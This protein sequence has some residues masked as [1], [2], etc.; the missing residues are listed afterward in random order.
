MKFCIFDVITDNSSLGI[1]RFN[2]LWIDEILYI[3]CDYR[4]LVVN[5]A[6]R[7]AVVNWW[8]FV[9]LMWLQTTVGVSQSRYLRLWIDEILYIWCDYRQHDIRIKLY[10]NKIHDKLE[11]KKMS[12]KQQNRPC[13]GRFCC[14]KIVLIADMA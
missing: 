4:Q 10:I 5:D 13:E 1:Q 7:L 12:V 9:Y 6:Y 8:N 2:V 3:W 14:F 11:I